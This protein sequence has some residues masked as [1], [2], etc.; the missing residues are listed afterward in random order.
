M[1]SFIFSTDYITDKIYKHDNF[2]NVILDSFSSPG[3]WPRG[4]TWDG[5]NIYS[6]DN[7]G[8]RIYKH[9]GFSA[10]LQTH[11]ASPS[12]N[13]MG[14]AWDGT[15]LYSSD[16]ASGKVYKHSGFSITITDSFQSVGNGPAGLTWD[17]T[18]TYVADFAHQKIC[19]HSGF[20]SS[21]LDS[22][23][24]PSTVVHGLTWDGTNLY[25]SDANTDKLYKH[26]GFSNTI[27]D[28]FSSPNVAPQDLAWYKEI[29]TL[30]TD[31]DSGVTGKQQ[32]KVDSGILGAAA[33]FTDADS[34]IKGGPLTEV[35]S[36]IFGQFGA[37]VG[38]GIRGLTEDIKSGILS[39]IKGTDSKDVST[40]SGVLGLGLS[41]VL[42]GILG[43]AP[44]GIVSGI[45]GGQPDVL[46][47]DRIWATFNNKTMD[48]ISSVSS[49]E[50]LVTVLRVLFD[51]DYSKSNF[52]KA[53][54]LE[55]KEAIR[56]YGRIEK[57][58]QAYWLTSFR[59]AVQ[60]GERQLKYYGRPKWSTSFVSSLDYAD[61]PSGEW[62]TLEEHPLLPIL[63]KVLVTNAPLDLS[64]GEVSFV[65][66]KAVGDPVEVEITRLSEAYEPE[67]LE[68][69]KIAY[70]DGIATFTILNDLGY[71]LGGA[72]AMLDG[73]TTRTTDS[74]GQVQFT[75]T[76]GKHRLLVEASGYAPLEFEV[77]V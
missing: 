34:G 59:L 58:I 31:A 37:S 54:Q 44:I 65:V 36:G 5:I 75:T 8:N 35:D 72:S 7:F 24:A 69:L 28:S 14:L 55:V 67:A 29:L 43:K 9:L 66:E 40:D 62:V 52:R 56:K 30:Q 2:S 49:Q 47:R 25:S 64:A 41:E 1:S 57:E 73:T 3:G 76:R 48:S 77:E 70:K 19:K 10:T 74:K 32:S 53:V 63:G 13:P 51:Y 71:P 15:N 46:L 33:L 6:T 22:F 42:G 4:L 20:S 38:A 11:F 21:V 26:D 17:G 61:I 23:S 60:M 12:S 39:G 45:I 68:G 27:L 16:Y 50:D 18:N